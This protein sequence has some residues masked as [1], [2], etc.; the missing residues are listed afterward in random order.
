VPATRPRWASSWSFIATTCGWVARALIGQALRV[1]LDASDLVQETFLKAHHD[2][3]S[4]LG[5]TEPELTA[6]LRQ[7]PVRTLAYQAKHHRRQGRDYKRHEWLDA[8]LDRSSAAIHRV[9]EAQRLAQR[10]CRPARAGGAAG[11]CPGE[12]TRRLPRGVH[13]A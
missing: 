4:F 6:W 2:F 8:M 11:R 1:R 7:I 12:I 10:P 5:S 9:L 3:A 13:P